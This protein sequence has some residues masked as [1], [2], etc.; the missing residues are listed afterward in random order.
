MLTHEL[1]TPL[2]VVRLVL[3]SQTPVPELLTHATQAVQDMDNVIERCLQAGQLDDDHLKVQR[4]AVNL[5]AEYWQLQQSSASPARLHLTMA[6]D[7]VL[8][9]DAKL[10]RIVLANLIDNA[11][12]YSPTDTSVD[13]LIAPGASQ[14]RAGAIFSIQNLPGTAGWP[15]TDKVFQKYYR[16]RHAHHQT[17]SGLGLYLVH[18]MAQLIGGELRYAPDEKF[19][20]F[21]LWLPL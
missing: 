10:L 16:S 15:D 12:K 3:G 13:I 5:R 17:G 19:V 1:K 14:T 18:S 9:T 11:L 6:A 8:H 7:L 21:T 4:T 20:R 2:S